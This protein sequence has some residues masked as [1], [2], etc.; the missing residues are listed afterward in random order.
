MVTVNAALSKQDFGIALTSDG[1]FSK[2]FHCVER[3]RKLLTK[4]HVSL[5]TVL[6]KTHAN[7]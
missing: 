4:K 1:L 3:D 5:C 6:F 2:D 7:L